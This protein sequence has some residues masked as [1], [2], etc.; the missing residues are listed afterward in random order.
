MEH[1]EENEVKKEKTQREIE[2][3]RAGEMAKA[4]VHYAKCGECG[5]VLPVD[6][7]SDNGSYIVCPKCL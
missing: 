6:Q 7:M 1:M 3:E 5:V 4:V 2:E